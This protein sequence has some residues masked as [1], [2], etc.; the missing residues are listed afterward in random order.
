[1]SDLKTFTSIW[2]GGYYVGSNI[3]G[4]RVVRNKTVVMIAHVM[5]AC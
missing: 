1:M 2:K 3:K 4:V 5:L